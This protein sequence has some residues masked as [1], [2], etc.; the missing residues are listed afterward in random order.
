[1]VWM[2]FVERQKLRNNNNNNDNDDNDDDDDDDN[3][4]RRENDVWKFNKKF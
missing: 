4:G 1:M 2:V 3:A